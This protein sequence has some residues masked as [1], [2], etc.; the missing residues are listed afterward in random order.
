MGTYHS[1][2]VPLDGSE[3]GER[4]IPLAVDLVRRNNARLELAMVHQPLQSFATAVEMPEVGTGVS[5]PDEAA[6]RQQ[7]QHF[8]ELKAVAGLR[9]RGS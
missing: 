4:A 5:R 3:F 6:P 1:I 8:S 7:A 2:L 9:G